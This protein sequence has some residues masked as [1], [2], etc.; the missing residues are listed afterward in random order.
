MHGGSP[1]ATVGGVADERF[2]GIAHGVAASVGGGVN[3]AVL[4]G[5]AEKLAGVCA[6]VSQGSAGGDATLVLG[7]VALILSGAVEFGFEEAAGGCAVLVAVRRTGE[8]FAHVVVVVGL[9]AFVLEGGGIGCEEFAT[10][11]AN[12]SFGVQD[13][14]RVGSAIGGGFEEAASVAA[15]AVDEVALKL[16]LS[17]EVDGIGGA[18]SGGLGDADLFSADGASGIPAA[19]SVLDAD[20][21]VS[22]VAECAVAGADVVVVVEV[23]TLN[24]LA[25]LRVLTRAASVAH[26]VNAVPDTVLI[27]HTVELT[28]VTNIATGDALVEG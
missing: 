4:S 18:T 22:S 21:L 12:L 15:D 26:V 27:A 28:A 6:D 3:G 19:A 5:A 14:A 24:G 10:S 2:G 25:G 1:D 11:L 13:A 23:A 7:P 9:D 20:G 17:V 16:T 8:D